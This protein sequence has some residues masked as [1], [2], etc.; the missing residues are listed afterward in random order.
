M[1][2]RGCV[3]SVDGLVIAGW[4]KNGDGPTSIDL[5]VDDEF[6]ST[7]PSVRH[8]ADLKGLVCPHGFCGF[9]VLM[10][11]LYCDGQRRKAELKFAGT[12]SV[13]EHGILTFSHLHA[14]REPV[15]VI[16]PHPE[17]GTIARRYL[18]LLAPMDVV[19]GEL[20]R[21]G[22]MSDG[23]YI[24]LNHGLKNS[25]CYSFGIND[26]V[27]WDAEM[28]AR[29]CEVFQYDH[30]IDFLPEEDPRFHWHKTGIA[31]TSNGMFKSITDIVSD[32]NHLGR[33]I[34]L[35][36]DI[37]GHEWTALDTDVIGDTPPVLADRD[38]GAWLFAAG[39]L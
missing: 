21:V 30:T 23:G 37:E 19:R 29:G 13:L 9:N 34:I 32:N 27:R 28:A 24:M 36:C 31:E 8:R 15:I 18:S 1:T 17:A 16:F 26:D 2:L 39:R 25:I 35:K 33:D 38:G 3:D 11:V 22:G 4:A 7:T 14:Y 10:P 6:V 20:I 12:D 5:Y